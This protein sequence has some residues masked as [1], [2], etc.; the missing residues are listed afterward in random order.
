MT[1]TLMLLMLVGA[2]DVA[3]TEETSTPEKL[4]EAASRG[5]VDMRWDR[6]GTRPEYVAQRLERCAGLVRRAL[7]EGLKVEGAARVVAVAY[8]ESNFRPN[9]V[10]AH[11]ELGMLQIIP[12]LHCWRAKREDGSCDPELAGIRYLRALQVT[13]IRAAKKKRKKVDWVRV[14]A[15]YNGSSAYGDKVDS[16]ARSALKRFW[17]R[18]KRS[19]KFAQR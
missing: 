16:Y 14:L 6:G 5:M 10:G 1:K 4:C 3:P 11:G 9:A 18:L 17:Y 2:P 7:T 15:S 19:K 8:N 13:E 12:K